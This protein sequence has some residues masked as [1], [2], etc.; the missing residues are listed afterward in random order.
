MKKISTALYILIALLI[1]FSS[2]QSRLAIANQDWH[3]YQNTV[4]SYQSNI[5]G[6]CCEEKAKNMMDLIYEV[7]PK[8]CVELGVFGGSS[9][10]PTAC[11]LKF[12][13]QGV[14][15][16]IDP[17]RN[18]DCL[19]GYALDDPNYNWWN[20]INLNDIY[21]GFEKMLY[22]YKLRFYCVVM[23]MTGQE[24]LSQFAD[25]SIDIL[26]IDGNHTENAALNDAQM[27]LPKVK[28]GGYV[29]FDD[30]CWPTTK[31]ALEFMQSHC[32][33]DEE[34]STAEYFLFKKI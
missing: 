28:K 12:L 21:D 4:L 29:W 19:E 10:H 22:D 6:W 26:H 17:W 32:E 16:A 14:V 33:K 5:P 3:H 11:A 24:A 18:L 1:V 30:V 31:S 15:Y 25:E 8:I 20:S 13:K 23:R 9:I 27:Y 2:I 34:R 7:K